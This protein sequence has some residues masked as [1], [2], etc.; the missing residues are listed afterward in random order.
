MSRVRVR[1]GFEPTT[2]LFA[3]WSYDQFP[4]FLG[5]PVIAMR[6]DGVVQVST[7]GGATFKPVLVT[8]HKAGVELLEKLIALGLQHKEAEQKFCAEWRQKVGALMKL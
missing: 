4:Y 5:G 3:F 8:T 6:A 1:D 2:N 7:Y